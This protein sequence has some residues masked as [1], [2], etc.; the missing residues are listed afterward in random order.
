M[1][2]IINS[3]EN[4]YINEKTEK[5]CKK[6]PSNF[7]IPY[8]SAQNKG[9]NKNIKTKGTTKNMATLLDAANY[10]IQLYYK[11]DEKY[12]CTKTKVEKIL[13]IAQMTALYNNDKI[14]DDDISINPCGTGFPLL[15]R[16]LLSDIIIGCEEE[17]GTS[18]DINNLKDE[19]PALYAIQDVLSLEHK[20]LLKEVFSLFGNYKAKALGLLIDE[21]KMNICCD[22][23]DGK[24]VIDQFSLIEYLN[25]NKNSQNA[26]INFI[27]TYGYNK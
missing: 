16:F 6:N 7:I 2:I 23:V 10:I 18:I 14:F 15:S 17:N 26:I 12:T 1:N 11:A 20:N 3:L 19:Y 9:E 21:F 8:K 24:K 13:S 27:V 22:A 4:L 25:K 5:F